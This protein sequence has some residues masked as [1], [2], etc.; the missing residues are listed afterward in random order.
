MGS[1][2]WQCLLPYHLLYFALFLLVLLLLPAMLPSQSPSSRCR[3]PQLTLTVYM[4]RI[5]RSNGLD[6]CGDV[7]N[8]EQIAWLHKDLATVDR[9]RTPWVIAMSHFPMY[10]T[11]NVSDLGGVPVS[12][13][14]F[15]SAEECEYS[16]DG[17]QCQPEG[18]IPPSQRPAAP[19][20][21]NNSNSHSS[22]QLRSLRRQLGL[23]HGCPGPTCDQRGTPGTSDLEPIFYK[24]GVDVYWAGHVHF[25]Q[26]FSGPMWQGQVISNGTDNPNGVLHVTSGNGG[27]PGTQPCT[28]LTYEKC[29]SDY[30]YTRLTIHNDTDL[31]WEQLSNQ[32]NTVVDSWTIHQSRHGPFPIPPPAPPLP[33]PPPAPPPP[34]PP[35]APTPAPGHPGMVWEC[36]NGVESKLPKLKSTD[37]TSGFKVLGDCKKACGTT[38][39]C[40]ALNWHVTDLHCHVLVGSATREEW[41]KGI[42]VLAGFDSCVLTKP[43]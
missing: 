42:K 14:A 30:S 39:G 29:H 8:Q 9:E 15:F 4:Y 13:M 36:Q 27:P 34:A 35:P 6:L 11:Q 17:M 1:E 19:S 2:Y 40:V 7:C 10:V 31:L 12:E 37:L 3:M 18:W 22:R 33:A 24:Y 16:S 20:S 5:V 25:Y 21:N 28:G 41:K 23:P 26:R 43:H 38:K 32:N